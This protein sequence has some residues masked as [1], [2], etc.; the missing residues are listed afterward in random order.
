MKVVISQGINYTL[1][2]YG[3]SHYL[4]DSPLNMFCERKSVHLFL[5]YIP[6]IEIAS[7]ITSHL[8]VDLG[9]AIRLLLSSFIRY[10]LL[11]YIIHYTHHLI[12]K[13]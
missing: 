10:P 6:Y 8:T 1:A 2:L 12:L 5:A 13:S 3:D 7:F 4:T 9:L 11:V